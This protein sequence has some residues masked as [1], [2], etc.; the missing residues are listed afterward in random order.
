MRLTHLTF[1]AFCVMTGMA[2]TACCVWAQNATTGAIAGTV[3]DST[4][5]VIVAANVQAVATT[6]GQVRTASTAK[7]GAFSILLLPP[8]TY[9]VVTVASGFGQSRIELVNVRVTETTTLTI[10]LHPQASQQS[11]EVQAQVLGVNTENSTTGQAIEDEVIRQLPLATQNFQQLLTLSAGAQSSLNNAEQLGRGDVRIFVNGQREDNNNYLIE[12][13]TATDYNVA[14]LT[15]TPLPS[16]DVVQEFKVQTSL[17]DASTGRNGGGVVNAILRTGTNQWHGDIFEFFRNDALN[18]N[19]FFLN[20]A[21]QER[22]QLR[23][24]IFGGSLGGPLGPNAV[25]GYIF[26]NYQGTRQSSGI[27]AG[28]LISTILPI[29]PTDRSEANL[30]R[31]FFGNSTTR[32]DP[33]VLKLLNAKGDQFCTGPNGLLIPSIP[34]TPGVNA[35]GSIASGPFTCSRPGTFTDNQFTLSWDRQFN[36]NKDKLSAR[37]F[38]SNSNSFKPFGAG[39]LQSSL[40]GSISPTDLNFPYALPVNARFL[41]IPWT[42]VFSETKI[43]ELRIGFVRINNQ[44]NN[45]NPITVGDLGINRPTNNVTQ[46]IY[47]FTLVSSGF[48]IGPTPGAN[49]TQAQNNFVFQDTLSWVHGKHQI[50]FGGEFD[51]IFLFKNFPQVFNGQFFFADTPASGST[52]A[53]TDFQNFLLGAPSF[54][55]GG[56]GVY[57]HAYRENNFS[58]FAQDDYRVR[59]DLT[60]NVGLRVEFNQAAYDR[61][62][63]IDNVIASL[64][65]QGINPFVYPTCVDQL[66]VPGMAGTLNKTAHLN[67]YSTGLGPRVGFAYDLL[68]HHSTSIRGGFGIYYVREDIGSVD[69]NSFNPP[70]I[71]VVANPGTPGNLANFYAPTQP[72]APPNPNTLPPGGVISPAF[73]PVTSQLQGF[74]TATGAPTKDTSQTPVYNNN[75]IDLIALQVQPH[76]VVPSTQQWNLSIQ[77]QLPHSFVLE[78]GY[79]GSHDVHLRELRDSLQSLVAT[80]QN[81]L[82]VPGANGQKFNIT[83]TTVANALARSYYQGLNG[84]GDF[85]DVANDAYSHYNAFNATLS[86]QMGGGYL[87]AAYTF[88]RTTDAT[89]TGNTAFNTAFNDQST[90]DTSR[91]L[92]DFDRTNRLAI[93]Y[94]QNLPF[95]KGAGGLKEGLLGGWAVSGITIFQSGA[96]FSILDSDAGSAYCELTTITTGASYKPGATHASGYTSGSVESRLNDYVNI[97]A[98]EP[99]PVIGSDGLATG[100]GNLGRNIY[101]GPFQQGWDLSLI[102]NIP[103]KERY[104]VRF[105]TDFFNLFNHPVFSNPAYTDV[106]S[107]PTFGQITSTVN[108]PR[109]IQFSLKVAF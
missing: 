79:N 71:P 34:G 38:F 37:W 27:D 9:T 41:T 93:S 74:V 91:G 55:F 94:L 7:N 46:S 39:G 80:P 103:I 76:F 12:G 13:I 45:I 59:K 30:S 51:P 98:F 47:K 68:G 85:F 105:T 83:T 89:S 22:P 11:V 44:A 52:P 87:Q 90:L 92:A 21:D 16:P 57:N 18:A 106:E 20:R 3:S 29:I 70:F 82:V 15:N 73:V 84:Y 56:G 10:S 104:Q 6:T 48:Q 97:A 65:L 102:K 32:I 62:C 72:P 4:G 101:R 28:T 2:L 58:F 86:R 100:F 42:H 108:N 95:F 96:P 109:I 36:N 8:G 64:L 88:S 26:G 54:N 19:D 77:R 49:Q 14:E 53:L 33:V 63:H 61:D 1:S 107:S 31:T 40:G 69:Q 50:R 5:A 24:N 99:A 60:I 35:D 17:Y 23:Q 43:N 66:G 67:E 78:V 81:P 25:A 75:M